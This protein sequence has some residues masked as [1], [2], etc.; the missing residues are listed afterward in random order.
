MTGDEKCI[1]QIL[2]N[3]LSNAIK[4]T[5]S[6]TVSLSVG[7]DE[8]D[9][10]FDNY[11]PLLAFTVTDT[12]RGMTQEQISSL[13]AEEIDAY[14]SESNKNIQGSGLGI[15]IVRQLVDIMNG[16]IDI[17]STVDV[18]TA[19]T[20]YIP[21]IADG[22]ETL[23]KENV[24]NLQN[25][26]NL[27]KSLKKFKK[28]HRELMP[29]GRVLIVD[30]IESNI[31]VMKDFLMPY[32]I[33][34]DVAD[35]G[36]KAIK[37][38]KNGEVY[39]IIFMDHMMPEMDGIEATK[40]ILG[41][42]YASPII[43]LTANAFV[44]A[45]DM[46]KTKGF[47]SY[48]S[49]P[50]NIVNLDSILHKFIRDKQPPEVLAQVKSQADM[51]IEDSGSFEKN[52]IMKAFL[53]DAQRSVTALKAFLSL[54]EFDEKAMKNFIIH[55]HSMKSALNNVEQSELSAVAA[56]LEK[57]GREK[58]LTKINTLTPKF[59]E[60]L[61]KIIKENTPQEEISAEN[62]TTADIVFLKTQMTDLSKAC[63]MLDFN[64]VKTICKDLTKKQYSKKK[65][66]L[67]DEI[68]ENVLFGDF[69]RAQFLASAENLEK[70]GFYD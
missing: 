49:K 45:A 26:E 35:S 20:V 6:G 4:Y 7:I 27:Q 32:K 33:V 34:V 28:I 36:E 38:V 62:N 40:I 10:A 2:N 14:D 19:V 22:T 63:E 23:G 66:D 17:K 43:A 8:Q 11:V 39:D 1:K 54:A 25:L 59:L 47:T 16:R 46:F 5:D 48:L 57:S 68:C 3:L 56:E 44:G 37:K 12:G 60:Q 65:Q 67:I 18:G 58:V 64:T 15:S 29:Y 21:Q 53:R 52:S 42:G 50:I 31:E 69:E 9:A 51:W 70:A 55:V 13:F 24:E 41:S 61:E 30:D